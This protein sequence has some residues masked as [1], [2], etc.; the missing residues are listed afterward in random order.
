MKIGWNLG[1]LATLFN[2]VALIFF[3]WAIVLITTIVGVIVAP[4]ILFVSII[5]GAIGFILSLIGI[6][7]KGANWL[8][9]GNLIFSA[10]VVIILAILAAVYKN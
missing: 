4:L 2:I 10:L 9:F 8:C 1:T 3:I 7:R 5:L 6:Y